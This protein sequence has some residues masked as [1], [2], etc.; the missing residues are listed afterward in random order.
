MHFFQKV[1][2]GYLGGFRYV[3]GESSFEVGGNEAVEGIIEV[4]E[5]VEREVNEVIEAQ[6][7]FGELVTNKLEREEGVG[8]SAAWVNIKEGE[9]WLS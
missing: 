2:I 7:S 3:N 8:P 9:I 4:W 1:I 5:G 6:V